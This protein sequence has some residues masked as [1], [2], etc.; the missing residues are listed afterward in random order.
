MDIVQYRLFEGVPD[1]ALFHLLADI[2]REIFGFPETAAHLS[3]FLEGR[4]CIL[5]CLA[6]DG[7][8]PVGFKMGFRERGY[9]FESWRG[10]VLENYRGRGIAQE[11]L[12]R[13][14]A[15]CREKGFRCTE[16]ACLL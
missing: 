4:S 12:R 7:E 14:H 5:I 2:N 6:F 10:G 11:L 8:T 15:W 3:Q 13:Q 9:Y 1:N 16:G